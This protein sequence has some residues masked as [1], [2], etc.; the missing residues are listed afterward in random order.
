MNTIDTIVERTTYDGF[1]RHG[2][3]CYVHGLRIGMENWHIEF[4]VSG[5]YVSLGRVAFTC[6]FEW[7]DA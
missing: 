7:R 1:T 6:G 3:S 2:T 5:I 4:F